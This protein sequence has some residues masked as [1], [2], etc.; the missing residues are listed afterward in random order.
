[1]KKPL[2]I[3][4]LLLALIGVAISLLRPRTSDTEQIL[5]VVDNIKV[6]VEKK[7]S[8]EILANISP[9]YEDSA[10]ITRRALQL[11]TMQYARTTGKVTVNI[12]DYKG[13]KIKGKNASMLLSV[14]VNYQE[15]GENYKEKGSVEFFFQKEKRRWLLI[16]AEGW[17]NWAQQAG[18]GYDW[19]N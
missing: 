11:M 18:V 15:G 7:N 14:E 8:Q 16:K 9:N 2:L 10:Q 12:T 19:G 4:L 17:Q 6:A 3:L 13:P 5:S 1:M